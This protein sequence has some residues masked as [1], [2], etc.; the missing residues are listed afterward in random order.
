MFYNEFIYPNIGYESTKLVCLI[1]KCVSGYNTN[2]KYTQTFQQIAMFKNVKFLTI[3][4]ANNI[5]TVRNRHYSILFFAFIFSLLINRKSGLSHDESS[6]Y[7]QI[8]SNEYNV[9]YIHFRKV[10]SKG[11]PSV[12]PSVTEHIR[13]GCGEFCL[14]KINLAFK[15][16]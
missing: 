13:I 2:C 12:N 9:Q 15:Y 7:L 1:L 6:R 3:L 10:E 14:Q 8:K 5:K 4:F 11:N 16:V